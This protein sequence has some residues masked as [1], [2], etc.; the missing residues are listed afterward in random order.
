M[1]SR[2]RIRSELL[3]PGAPLRLQC[4]TFRIGERVPPSAADVPPSTGRVACGESREKR[5][6]QEVEVALGVEEAFDEASFNVS[7]QWNTCL[8]DARVARGCVERRRCDSDR[9]GLTLGVG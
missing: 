5:Q 9:E 1:E 7:R 3:P 6:A 4:R 2:R 8:D